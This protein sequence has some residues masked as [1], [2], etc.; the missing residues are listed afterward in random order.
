MRLNLATILLG[1]LLTLPVASVQAKGIRTQAII[2]SSAR[3]T[4]KIVALTFDDGPSVYTPEVLGVLKRFH[5]PATFFLIGENVD[6]YPQYVRDEVKQGELVGDHTFTH[7]DLETIS[8][9]AVRWQL[10]H[11]EAAIFEAAHYVPHWF[12]P[13]YGSVNASIADLAAGLGLRTVLWS[14]DPSDWSL[15]GT[16]AII[17][18]VVGAVVPGSVVLMH[19]G[20]GNRGET[21]AALPVIIEKLRSEGYRFVNLDQLFGFAPLTSCPSDAGQIFGRDGFAAKSGDPMYKAWLALLCRGRNL[22]PAT[23]QEYTIH[24][25]VLAQNF[26]NTA[27]QIDLDQAKNT[28]S[29]TINWGA[30]A[31]AFSRNGVAPLWRHPITHAWMMRFLAY[32]GCGPALDNQHWVNGF[33]VQRFLRATATQQ[34]DGAVR[35][36]KT[37]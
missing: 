29:V 19:D 34:R 1:L 30:A 32:R 16:E 26:Y 37:A 27:H 2:Y 14:V 4:K 5:V 8:A 7:P 13:P 3:T 33:I 36:R 23:S 35:W 6:L 31:S 22:G 15:P 11:T 20:G 28:T 24:E 9:A 18:R 12:R 10:S 17:D 25:G 21:V